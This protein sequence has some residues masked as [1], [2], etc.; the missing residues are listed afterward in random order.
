MTKLR[1]SRFAKLRRAHNAYIANDCQRNLDKLLAANAELTH[2][3]RIA[4]RDE[5][6]RRARESK[7]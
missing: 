3:D 6:R 4:Y 7:P 5:E 1:K 2:D